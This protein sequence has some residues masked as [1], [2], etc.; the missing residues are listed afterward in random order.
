MTKL[1]KPTKPPLMK[2]IEAWALVLPDGNV[3]LNARGTPRIYQ[4]RTAVVV[5]LG[6][7]GARPGERIAR[8]EIKEDPR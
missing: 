8:V 4:S 6:D 7:V 1:T 3:S 5:A 2:P